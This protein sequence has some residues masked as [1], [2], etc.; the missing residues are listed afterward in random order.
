[1]SCQFSR[2][3]PGKIRFPRSNPSRNFCRSNPQI[4]SFREHCLMCL[5]NFLC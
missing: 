3:P 5:G 1:V 4:R 2:K